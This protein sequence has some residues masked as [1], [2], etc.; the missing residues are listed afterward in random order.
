MTVPICSPWAKVR[1]VQHRPTIF[2]CIASIAPH[3]S[4]DCIEELLPEGVPLR[5]RKGAFEAYT[6]A[7]SDQMQRCSPGITANP[8]TPPL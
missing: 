5:Y 4:T 1:H 7:L 2:E 3:N 6:S 8:S